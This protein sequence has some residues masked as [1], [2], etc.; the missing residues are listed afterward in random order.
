MNRL[1]HARPPHILHPWRNPSNLLRPRILFRAYEP[2]DH[3]ED[4]QPAPD[5]RRIVHALCRRG[6]RKRE[7][8]DDEEGQHVGAGDAVQDEA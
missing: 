1:H 3:H 7:A 8:E 2:P 4:R 6:Q 5:Q